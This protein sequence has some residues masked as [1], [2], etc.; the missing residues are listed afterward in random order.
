MDNSKRNFALMF[1]DTVLFVNAMAFISVNA[2]IPNFLNDLGASTF[3]ISL[4]SALVS[5][6]ALVSQPL[7]A[8]MAMGLSIKTT[9]FARVLSTQRIIFLIYVLCIPFLNRFSSNVS[10]ILFLVFWGIFNFFVGSYSPFFMSVLSKLIPVNQRG[11]LSG[12]SGA[13]GNVLAL[14]S[15]LLAGVLLKNVAYPYNYTWIFGIGALLLIIDA[16]DFA[17]MREE[18][19]TAQKSP[20]NYFKYI[21]EVPDALRGHRGY[22]ASVLGNSFIVISNTALSF[23]TLAAIRIYHAEPEQIALFTGIGIIVSIF[24]SSIFGIIADRFGHTYVLMASALCSFAAGIVVLSIHSLFAVYIAFALTS[25]CSGGYN[26]SSPTNLINNS[27]EDKVP[28]YASMNVMITLVSSSFITLL[29]GAVIDTFSF[30][31][32]F[33]LTGAAGAA[34][35]FTFHIV[36]RKPESTVQTADSSINATA[37]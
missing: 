34:G 12:F 29:A 9:A 32:L 28:L 27:P 11:R 14:G 35:F 20:I 30:T 24:G 16:W 1:L 19:D 25:L 26:I 37:E 2:V 36:N 6:G 7:F 23:Y 15:A 3:Q 33:I 8:Q 22:A 21:R 13:A 31:P 4:A 10:V 17:W 5:V 18:P